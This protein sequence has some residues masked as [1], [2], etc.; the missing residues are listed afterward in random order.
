MRPPSPRENDPGVCNLNG[1]AMGVPMRQDAPAGDFPILLVEDNPVSRRV[2][3]KSL[4]KAGYHVTSVENGREALGAFQSRFFPIVL[5][6]WLMPGMD[7]LELCKAVRKMSLP[8]YIFFVLLTAKDS[9][10]DIIQG[11]NAG[12]DDYLTKPVLQAE[13]MARIR[14]GVRILELEKSLK[15]AAEEIKA[16]S[17]TDPL[18]G[19]YNRRYLNEHLPQEIKR[20]RRYRRAFSLILCDIDH[21]KKINDTYGH[22][23]GDAALKVIVRRLIA[24]IRKGIDWIS[25]MGGEEFVLVLPET[26]FRFALKTAERLRQKIASK[27]VNL[28]D[29]HFF[30]T[31][32]FGVTG[33]NAG[34]LEKDLSPDKMISKADHYLYEAKKA[35]RN[36]VSGDVF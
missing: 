4:A 17:V 26:E 33:F 16:L 28:A 25:R 21:F 24:S 35:G 32:S 15:T 10:D 19:C 30:V 31:L 2:L 11:L 9:K 13:L 7:G 18:T 34:T 29:A 12:A 20:A 6:D 36:R 5:S 3:E 23:A 1:N 14:T 27:P 22:A 8:G